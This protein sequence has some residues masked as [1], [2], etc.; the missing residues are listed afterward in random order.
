MHEIRQLSPAQRKTLITLIV[1]SL[2]EPASG[3]KP[4]S[5]LELEGL[6]AEIW[7]GVDAQDYV[8][9]L[10]SEWDARP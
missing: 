3:E 2:T 9:G 4:H 8:D 5:I 10:R 7:A 6:G 1:D